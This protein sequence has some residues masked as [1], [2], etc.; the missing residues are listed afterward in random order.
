MPKPTVKERNEKPFGRMSSVTVVV[1]VVEA[2]VEASSRVC[3]RFVGVSLPSSL[4]GPRPLSA[5]AVELLPPGD[6]LRKCAA[7]PPT[8]A[9]PRGSSKNETVG[10]TSRLLRLR[11]V[12]SD[13]VCTRTRHMH[14][15]PIS[16]GLNLMT[17]SHHREK[18]S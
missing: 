2:A 1:M 14:D 11:V 16:N 13:A 17:S 15:T 5:P 10:L 6:R 8:P 4:L 9:G 18:S 12:A 7:G 3:R